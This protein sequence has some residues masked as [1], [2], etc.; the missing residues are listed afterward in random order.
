MQL[1]S[2]LLWNVEF[3]FLVLSVYCNQLENWL[4][5]QQEFCQ[6]MLYV[7]FKWLMRISLMLIWSVVYNC[8]HFFFHFLHFTEQ[9]NF[10]FRLHNN[11]DLHSETEYF[12]L[13]WS[14]SDYIIILSYEIYL[15][16]YFIENFTLKIDEKDQ[17]FWKQ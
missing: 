14:I 1:T 5:H 17:L 6:H 11:I 9:S 16:E 2:E 8:F 15:S 13:D 7:W 4:Q 3:D 10:R 12:T